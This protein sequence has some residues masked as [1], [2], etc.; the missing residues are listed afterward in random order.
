[1][2]GSG[3]PKRSVRTPDGPERRL[4]ESTSAMS[5]PYAE[6]PM[7]LAAHPPAQHAATRDVPTCMSSS[8]PGIVYVGASRSRGHRWWDG[9]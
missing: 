7:L 1:M 2:I 8:R 4:L 5:A 6:L 9:G 3:T